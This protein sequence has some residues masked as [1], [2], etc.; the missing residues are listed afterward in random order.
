MDVD[1]CNFGFI[2][3]VM[4]Q[5]SDNAAFFDAPSAR[6]VPK[7]P[8][9]AEGKEDE[10]RS[11]LGAALPYLMIQCRIAHFLKVIWRENMGRV[12][13][14]GKMTDEINKWLKQ[15]C[16]Q[17]TLDDELAAKYPLKEIQVT[18]EP[19]PGKPGMFKS[20]IQMV[21]H[22][23]LKG[24]EIQLSMVASSTRRRLDEKRSS[25]RRAPARN[26]ERGAMPRSAFS[27][28]FG[29]SPW[30]ANSPSSDASPAA[31]AVGRCE[32]QSTT[33]NLNT[34]G[35]G[36]Q[37]P[38]QAAELAR[39][40]RALPDYGLPAARSAWCGQQQLHPDHAGR[41]PHHGREARAAAEARPR[42]PQGGGHKQTLVFRVDAVM[43]SSPAIRVWYETSIR[44]TGKL[45]VVVTL[46]RIGVL[47]LA[48]S[49]AVVR[50]SARQFSPT[51][52]R[53]PRHHGP[54]PSV[55]FDSPPRVRFS[56]RGLQLT[57]TERTSPRGLHSVVTP[58]PTTEN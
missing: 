54:A 24:V 6:R 16:R 56:P 14:G 4:R 20:E 42:V 53:P 11:R 30:H 1:L 25:V 58:R 39:G 33:E 34:D 26:A 57:L 13:D 44:R 2:P 52:R 29:V 7:F 47:L 40:R 31:P 5:G 23:K 18:A 35:I 45:D 49:P 8:D 21:P 38:D 50:A 19:V 9:T 41:D 12:M 10:T 27:F 37:P 22:F 3:L 51:L 48:A 46:A 17:G 43:I 28:P 55:Q 32:Q 15:Y 36:P